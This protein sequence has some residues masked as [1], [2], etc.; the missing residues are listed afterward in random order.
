MYK[1]YLP[2]LFFGFV[3]LLLFFRIHVSRDGLLEGWDESIYT[4]L[5]VEFSKHPDLVLYYNGQAWLEKP[6]LIGYITGII[7]LISPYNTV[8]LRSFFGIVSI[9]NLYLVWKISKDLVKNN[10]TAL[11]APA[12]VINTYLFLERGITGNTDTLLVLGILGYYAYRDSFW[13]KLVFLYIAVW[14]KSL[15]GFL[16]LILELVFS[17]RR[18]REI[19]FIKQVSLLILVPSIWYIYSF[20]RFGQEFTQ[21]HFVEQIFS[22]ASSTLES[23]SGSW[24]FYLEF[25]IKTAPVASIV[26]GVGIIFGTHKLIKNK[27]KISD[28]TLYQPIFAGLLYLLII[29]FSKSKLEWYLLPSI[30]LLSLILPIVFDRFNKIFTRSLLLLLCFL[31]C[32]FLAFVPV[33]SRNSPQ[34][35]ELVSLA[36]CI[37]KLP[38]QNVTLYQ[39]EENINNYFKLI[40][41]GGSISSTFRYG[42][43]PAFV[44]Y[45]RKSNII[46]KY[47]KPSREYQS[48][49][50]IM[51]IPKLPTSPA[52]LEVKA[53]ETK[54]YTTNII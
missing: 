25:M 43:N 52:K 32:L 1:R 22:R 19:K 30:Y 47:E 8:L 13:R 24:S 54:N 18:L 11:L 35:I 6:P 3:S 33:F 48:L 50:Q 46:F 39:S 31:G 20:A 36:K 28:F 29:S 23:H 4:Q 10:I 14:T 37:S 9:A 2:W 21:K 34:N 51:V 17:Y 45:A 53:C 12:L 40:E 16:P 27:F 42:D 26:L 49:D 41:S 5:G 7:H 15:L 44:Y 38:Q